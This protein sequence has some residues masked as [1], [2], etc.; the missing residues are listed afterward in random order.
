MSTPATTALPRGIK[1]VEQLAV[2]GRRTFVRVDLN[3]PIKDKK[4]KGYI[5]IF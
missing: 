5:Y 4:I 2:E 3:V 1:H